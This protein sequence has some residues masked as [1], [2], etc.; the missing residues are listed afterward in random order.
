MKITAERIEKFFKKQCTPEEAKEVAAFLKANPELLD[1]YLNEKEWTDV[2]INDSFSDE[3]WDEIWRSIQNKNKIS[4]KIIWIKR[5][6]VAACV[7]GLLAFTFYIA[8]N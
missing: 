5:S 4:S 6:A 3:F 1:E 8:T 7:A 2:K